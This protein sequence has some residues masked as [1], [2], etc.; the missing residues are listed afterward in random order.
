MV[1]IETLAVIRGTI[2]ARDRRAVMEWAAANH[3]AIA[4]AWNNLNP[5]LAI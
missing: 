5:D 3:S 1:E 2:P 4:A